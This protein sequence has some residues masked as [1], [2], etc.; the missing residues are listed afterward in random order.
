MVLMRT[1]A[2]RKPLQPP[3]EAPYKVVEDGEHAFSL[4]AEDDLRKQADDFPPGCRRRWK[5]V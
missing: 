2:T 4:D 5:E 3:Y 1:Y